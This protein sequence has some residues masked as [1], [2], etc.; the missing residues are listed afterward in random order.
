MVSIAWQVEWPRHGG[1]E[2][3]LA[4]ILVCTLP[5]DVRLRSVP[6]AGF[7][8][9]ALVILGSVCMLRRTPLVPFLGSILLAAGFVTHEV[10]LFYIAIFCLSALVCDWQRFWKPVVACI[11]TAGV[12]VVIEGAAYFVVLGDFLA[13]WKVAAGTT[14]NLPIGVDPDT[15]IEGIRFFLWPLEGLFFS[16]AFGVDLILLVI[17]GV[18]AWRRLEPEQRILL[19]S[20][21]GLYVWLGYGTQVPWAYKPFYRQFQ[22]YF[23][24]M[25][26]LA[27]VLPFALR[28]ACQKRAWVAWGTAGFVVFVHLAFLVGGGRWGQDVDVSRQLLHYAMNHPTQRFLTDVATMNHMY[29]LAGF[30]MPPNVV[31]LNGPAVETHL[32]LNKEPRGVPRR[33]FSGGDIDAI[34]INLEGGHNRPPEQEF[35]SFVTGHQ[36]ER[37]SVAPT[38]YRLPFLP[39][40]AFLE[41]R[42]FMVLSLGGHVVYVGDERTKVSTQEPTSKD[43]SGF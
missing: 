33:A 16:R 8:S 31:C 25:L 3:T 43:H 4:L 21:L 26:G 18:V 15:G 41:A 9:A 32:L 20:S 23:P 42:E 22:Y 5:L 24:V 28:Y 14:K 7:M 19:G 37:F 13:R 35:L 38:R 29:V 36:G 34:L 40:L 11:A 6:L 39:F 27:C 2:T 10:S 12:L 1:W 30:R 17:C